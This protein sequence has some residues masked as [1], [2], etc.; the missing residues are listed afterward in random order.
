MAELALKAVQQGE[1]RDLRTGCCVRGEREDMRLQELISGFPGARLLGDGDVEV[2]GLATDSRGL[3][4]GEVFFAL[5]GEQTDG[6]RFVMDAFEKGAAAAVVEEAVE[7]AEAA[8]QVPSVR[9]ALAVFAERFYGVP[10]GSLRMV[11]VTGTNGKTT[12]AYLIHAILEAAGWQPGLIGTVEHHLGAR[13]LPSSNSTPEAHDLQRMFWEMVGAG[14]RSAV[15]E[16]SSHG[17]ALGR[18]YGIGFET[19]VF[20]NITRDHLDFHPSSEAYL[21]AKALL[22]DNLDSNA[23]AVVNIDDPAV[24]TLLAQCPAHVMG[25]GASEGAA[26]RILEGRT[27]WRGTALSLETPVG[28]LD[29]SLALKGRFNLWN[30]AA[31]VAVGLAMG[32]APD[33]IVE[34][35]REVRVPGRFEEVDQGQAFGVIVDYAHTPDGLENVLQAARALTEGRLICVFGCGGD[36]DRGKRPEMGRVSAQRAD[37]T[38]VTSDNPRTEAPEAIIQ[39][40]LPGLGSA[41]YRI[42]PDRRRAIEAAIRLAGP[43][44]LVMIA[45]KGHED[46]QDIGREK[47]PFDDREVAREVLSAMGECGFRSPTSD[48]SPER[49]PSLE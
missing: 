45:G 24:E 8:V 5:R 49:F 18:V 32:V 44:D 2:T 47:I 35:V 43:E 38:V 39:E 26:V 21:A 14:C 23:Q 11:G 16:V 30:A 28:R 41:P 13:R 19:A 4:P 40:I 1:T 17:L 10:C 25:Y 34:A 20:T 3:K 15:M 12:T 36:R 27:T 48:D 7:V 37:L 46:Y 33:V 9:R 22:F 42:E 6:H 29:L 31:A